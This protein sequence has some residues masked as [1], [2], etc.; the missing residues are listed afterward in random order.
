MRSWSQIWNAAVFAALLALVGTLTTSWFTQRQANREP[1]LKKQLELCFEASDSAGRLAT[2]SDPFEWEKARREFWRLY[3]GVLSIVEDPEVE[4]AMVALG[5]LV[6]THPN[7][8][9]ELPMKSL[10]IPSYDLAH[11][12]R[13]LLLASWKIDLPELENKRMK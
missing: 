6:P 10:Q 9:P 3:W 1:F 8:N 7:T 11:S 12:I 13:H 4:G 5:E 2:Q